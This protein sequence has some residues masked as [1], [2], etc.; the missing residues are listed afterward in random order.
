MVRN[1]EREFVRA[2][3]ESVTAA[4]MAAV[5]SMPRDFRVSIS[6]APGK[7]VYPLSS[8]T[9]ILLYEKTRDRRRSQIMV[10][11]MKWALTDGQKLAPGL[12]YAPLPSEIVTLEMSALSS[13][14]GS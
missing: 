12:G 4:A 1:M 6:H 11:F 10:D 8:F 3:V 9:W 13:I 14:R 2:S 7:G 5:N